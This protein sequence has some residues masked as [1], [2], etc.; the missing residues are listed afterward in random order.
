LRLNRRVLQRQQVP[1][2]DRFVSLVIFVL[3]FRS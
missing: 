2:E 3:R 1:A